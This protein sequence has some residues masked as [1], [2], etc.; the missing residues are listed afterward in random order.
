MSTAKKFRG[1]RIMIYPTDSEELLV[2]TTVTDYNAQTNIVYVPELDVKNLT[3]TSVRVR[4]FAN[5]D[6]YEYN[7]NIRVGTSHIRDVEVALFRER[8]VEDR[9][10]HR[11]QV[12]AVGVIKSIIINRQEVTLHRPMSVDVADISASGILFEAGS[13]DFRIGTR[14]R[15]SVELMGQRLTS[16]YEIVRTQHQMGATVQY[17]CKN[18]LT[19][20]QD[21]KN[22]VLNLAFSAVKE[23]G[24]DVGAYEAQMARLEEEIGY[25]ALMD[26]VDVKEVER[27]IMGCIREMDAAVILNLVHR[28][29]DDWEKQA[30]HALNRAFLNGLMGVWLGVEDDYLRELVRMGYTGD[31]SEGDERAKLIT[32]ISDGY[33]TRAAFPV[34]EKS[35]VP[36]LF[37]EQIHYEGLNAPDGS[38][39]MLRRVLAEHIIQT[40][41]GRNVMLKNGSVAKVLFSL[42]NDI[43]RPIIG[44][45]QVAKQLEHPWDIMG[46]IIEEAV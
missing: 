41:I 12:D 42:H 38:R 4:I 39:L 26:A 27:K 17:G 19:S 15:L 1:C 24:G 44:V 28:K 23:T 5:P 6:L 20:A 16:I 2:D 14:V 18:L 10:Y 31:T 7:A 46:I 45:G 35:A 11:H 29:R 8:K 43:G 34:A 3:S 21:E 9:R 22:Y 37:L 33:D 36:L 30:R 40:M 25:P 13:Y 32:S